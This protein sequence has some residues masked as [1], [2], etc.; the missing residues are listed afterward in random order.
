[1]NFDDQTS[2][3]PLDNL[4]AQARWPHASDDSRRRLEGAWEE[5]TR[6][7]RRQRTLAW[8]M[9][10]AAVLLLAAGTAWITMRP[11]A[12]PANLAVVEPP[13]QVH[14]VSHVSIS[15]PPTQRE[16]LLLR[17]EDL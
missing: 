4:L 16:L 2:R 10:A 6:S 5:I 11:N 13:I 17:M 7:P 12:R 3:D 8:T 14:L 15:R 9:S 1:M